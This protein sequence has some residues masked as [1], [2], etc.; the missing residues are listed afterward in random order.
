MSTLKIKCRTCKHCW[1]WGKNNQ[2]SEDQISPQ[3]LRG[4][5]S[6]E[7]QRDGRRHEPKSEDCNHATIDQSEQAYCE[8]AR[9]ALKAALPASS[10][11]SSQNSGGTRNAQGQGSQEGL[12]HTTPE[13]LKA[14][15][16][17]GKATEHDHPQACNA[18]PSPKILDC[19]GVACIYNCHGRKPPASPP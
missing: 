14:A 3:A 16:M 13:Q 1:R 19:F 7:R 8:A 2:A 17:R 4:F 9:D 12:A 11:N 10:G 5:P 6:H 18:H 15:C